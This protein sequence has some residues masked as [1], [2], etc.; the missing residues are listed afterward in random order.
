MRVKDLRPG[1]R[2]EFFLHRDGALIAERDDAIVECA[3]PEQLAIGIYRSLG[4]RR[5][6]GDW[7]L[8][9]KSPADRGAA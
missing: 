2:T 8:Q 6:D 5:I 3:D 4:F 1:W 7:R 9:R